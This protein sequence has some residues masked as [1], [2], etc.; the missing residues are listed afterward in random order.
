MKYRKPEMISLGSVLRRI[1][2]T[3]FKGLV[4]VFDPYYYKFPLVPSY[5]LDG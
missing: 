4:G 3:G 2:Y 1:E 5:D